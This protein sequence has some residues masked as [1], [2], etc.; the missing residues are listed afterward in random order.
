MSGSK[1]CARLEAATQQSLLPARQ[2]SASPVENA[3]SDAWLRHREAPL[4]M[5]LHCRIP[6]PASDQGQD[7]FVDENRH[8]DGFDFSPR[9][10][11]KRLIAMSHTANT[12]T[13]AQTLLHLSTGIWSSASALGGGVA[14]RRGS[15]RE[16]GR[17]RPTTLAQAT[18]TLARV[19]S[20]R[21]LRALAALR[22]LS[23]SRQTGPFS[24]TRR[25]SET[26]RT[27]VPRAHCATFR[28][29]SSAAPT[30]SP[31]FGRGL[32]HSLSHWKPS[33]RAGRVGG[34]LW[35][36]LWAAPRR[37]ETGSSM[38]RWTG[39]VCPKRA[40]AVRDALRLLPELRTLVERRWGSTGS[41][42]EPCSRRQSLRR[43]AGILFELA[44]RRS[45][46]AAGATLQPPWAL[47]DRVV[48]RWPAIFVPSEVPGG[49]TPT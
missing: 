23:P 38:P 21:V 41:S 35:G 32:L 26:L 44:A 28:P 20:N 24:R 43:C 19:R 14:E 37:G 16:S 8:P 2:R 31:R 36:L 12:P 34:N 46:A 11:M 1:S 9:R 3:P 47:A 42:S 4:A 18:G 48:V 7:S 13:P 10:P 33:V 17:R 40:N 6:R 15:P 5:V 22:P 39:I 29:F 27:D 45:T 25:I 30:T 49:R